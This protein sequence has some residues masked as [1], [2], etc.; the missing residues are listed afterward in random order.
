MII[1]SENMFFG[2]LYR[3]VVTKG[4]FKSLIE[5]ASYKVFLNSLKK[6]SPD[7]EML[8]QFAN[9]IRMLE[10]CN[11]YDNCKTNTIFSS[12]EYENGENGFIIN[13]QN[14]QLIFK[15]YNYNETITIYIKRKYGNKKDSEITFKNHGMVLETQEDTVLMNNIIKD[16]MD[17]IIYLFSEYYNKI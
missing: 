12:K 2:F 15:L 1:N 8:W 9:F 3:K 17:S 11:W 7:F 16:T 14:R 13:K 4:F 6:T 10:L 5:K